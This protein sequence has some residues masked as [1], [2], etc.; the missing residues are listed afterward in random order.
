ML[1]A[2]V[3]AKLLCKPNS[4]ATPVKSQKESLTEEMNSG[5][6]KFL[7][8]IWTWRPEQILHSEQLSEESS[9][10]QGQQ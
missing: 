5:K 7:V 8:L 3:D 4:R 6:D 10:V 9:K 2:T 1:N